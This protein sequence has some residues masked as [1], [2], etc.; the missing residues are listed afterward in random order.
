MDITLKC[1]QRIN[2]I[3]TSETPCFSWVCDNTEEKQKYQDSYRIVVTEE[4][5]ETV[6]DSGTVRSDRSAFIKYGG[7]ALKSHTKYCWCAEIG[8]EGSVYKSDNASFVTGLYSGDWFAKWIGCEKSLNAPVFRKEFYVDTDFK[9]AYAYICGL[10]YFELIINGK[11]VG[12]DYFVPNQTDYDDVEYTNLTY[13][14]SGNTEKRVKYLAYDVFGY[15]KKGN[16]TV[17][18]RIGNGWYNQTERTIEGKFLYNGGLKTLFQLHAGNFSLAT[19]GTWQTGESPIIYNNIFFGEIYDAS[20]KPEWSPAEIACA[21]NAKLE[22]QLSPAD[23]VVEEIT[24]S[25]VCKNTYDAG[26]VVSGFATVTCC[27]NAGDEIEIYYSECINEDG[28]LDFK[29]TVGYEESDKF[30]IQK[31]KFILSG[32]GTEVYTPHFVWHGFRYFRIAAKSAEVVCV[33]VNNVHSAVEKRADFE[34]SDKLFNKIHSMYLNSQLSNLHGGVPTDCPHRERMGYTGDG[35]VS[36]NSAMYNF[37][38]Y[39]FYKKWIADIAG[40]QNKQTGFVAHSAPFTGG[41]GGYAWGSAIVIVPWNLYLQ[42]GDTDTLAQYYPNMKKWICYMRNKLNRN[43]LIDTEE[44]GSW[45]LGDWCLP[46][47][48]PWSCPQS[49][50]IKIPSELVNTCYYIHCMKICAMISGIL[51]IENE[52]EADIKNASTAVN[53]AFLND[54]YSN[55]EQGC[56]IFP[57]R[58][59]IVPEEKR[60]WVIT[61]M[62]GNL[63]RRNYH[64]DTGMYGTQFLL[65]VLDNIGMNSVACKMLSKT[66]YPSYGYMAECGATALWETWEGNGSQNHT[67]LGGFDSWFFYGLCGIKPSVKGGGY[68][69]FSISPFYSDKLQWATATINTVYGNL[70]VKWE[71]RGEKIKLQVKVPFNTTAVVFN[72]SEWVRRSCGEYSFYIRL[73]EKGTS[74]KFKN[75]IRKKKRTEF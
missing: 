4:N 51:N 16:N 41:G 61:H 44:E 37:D 36:S 70:C 47:D 12:S 55:G 49:E 67:A 73:K 23:R 24:P 60:N 9:S 21:P 33:K 72:G 64:F 10:G 39:N 8:V 56:D 59:D 57:L 62:L 50:N 75:T 38:I 7:K 25:E 27:G 52:F 34:C 19:D 32:N 54:F 15:L 53:N 31:D 5:G 69:N 6:W 11:K 58:T 2:P 43:G 48:R 28:T 29:S 42:Y 3:G 65:E 17:E 18:I 63:K 14:F 26:K 46:S 66:D 45:C 68:K 22:I 13:G 1:E 20:L 74:E 35:Q 40:T 71:R 30:Q